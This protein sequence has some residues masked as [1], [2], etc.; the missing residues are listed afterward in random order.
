M[1]A[2]TKWLMKFTTPPSTT[3]AK[4]CYQTVAR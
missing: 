2:L 3:P 4:S 1:D